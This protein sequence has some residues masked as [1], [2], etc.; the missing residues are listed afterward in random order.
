MNWI[1][2]ATVF[3]KE[4]RDTLRD[5]RTI[6]SMIIIPTLVMPALT[7]GV[8]KI[9]MKVDS[10]ARAETPSVMIIG[11]ED[12]PGVIAQLKASDKIRVLETKADW[13]ELIA[14][15]KIRAAAVL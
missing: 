2:I 3:C 7:F 8:G 4:L 5:K 15:K 14:E 12:S 1:S 10:A 9:A 13:K 11:G 6:R